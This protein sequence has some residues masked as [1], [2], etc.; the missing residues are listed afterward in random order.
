M[1][2]KALQCK[3]GLLKQ[4]GTGILCLSTN[5]Q[6]IMVCCDY[7][8]Y[9]SINV[10]VR[11]KYGIEKRN[12]KVAVERHYVQQ[13]HVSVILLLYPDL[14]LALSECKQWQRSSYQALVSVKL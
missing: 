12:I 1:P 9:G 6:T 3:V 5:V 2:T 14:G 4:L 13:R 10:K 7:L 8:A 11:R